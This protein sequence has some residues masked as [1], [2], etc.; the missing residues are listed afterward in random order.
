MINSPVINYDKLDV[1]KIDISNENN[2]CQNEYITIPF[3]N[4]INFLKIQTPIY[5]I[6]AGGIPSRNNYIINDIA[7]AKGFTI[8]FDDLQ[9]KLVEFFNKFKELDNMLSN[10]KFK[11]KQFGYNYNNYNYQPCIQY[12][13]SNALINDSSLATHDNST[14]YMKVRIDIDNYTNKI[15]TRVI[16]K[17]TNKVIDVTSIKDLIKYVHKNSQVRLIIFASNFFVTKCRGNINKNLNTN[18]FFRSKT[19]YNYG[20][21]FKI[22]YIE[23]DSPKAL[24][25][26]NNNIFIDD[27]DFKNSDTKIVQTNLIHNNRIYPDY[28]DSDYDKLQDIN[29]K[30]N[31]YILFDVFILCVIS[32]FLFTKYFI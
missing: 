24:L 3:Y 17:N 30:P 5:N 7:Q 4:D 12:S 22:L 29:T 25:F 21:I 8:S 10:D 14:N 18:Y 2:K 32:I 13:C 23:V 1:S 19:K 27:T 16:Q 11:K 6:T 20:I 9:P 15:K 26:K 31:I 28:T